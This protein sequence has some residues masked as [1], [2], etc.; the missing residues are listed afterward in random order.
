MR[1]S[2]QLGLG[3]LLVAAVALPAAESDERRE[4]D[5]HLL[6]DAGV[7]NDSAALLN[8]FRQ[9]TI[10]EATR[11]R[12]AALIR[13]LGDDDFEMREKA[14][15]ELAALGPQ[16]EPALRQAV[17]AADAEIA[18]RARRCLQGRK[19][20]SHD[21]VAAAAR[22]LAAVRPPQAVE[23]LLEYLPSACYEPVE[24]EIAGLLASLG[25]SEGRPHQ[26][27][28][29]AAQDKLAV[30][31]L[32]A[33][34]VLARAGAMHRPAAHKLLGDPE[35]RVRLFASQSLLAVQDKSAVPTLIALLGDGPAALVWQAEDQLY[36]IA[37]DKPPQASLD[38]ASAASREKCRAAWEAWWQANEERIDLAKLPADPQ[39][40]GL[41]VIG[42]FDGRGGVGRV[43][44]VGPDGKERWRIDDVPGPAD[45]RVLPNGRVLIAEH[46]GGRVT[47]RT[48]DGKV[49]WEQRVAGNPVSCQRLPNG[50]TFIAT[51]TELLEVTR[52]GK[53]VY[54]HAKP[55][56]IYR[57]QKLANGHILY[58]HSNSQIVEIESNGREVRTIPAGNTGGWGSVEPLANGRFLIS[59]YNVGK[60]KEIDANGKVY[61]E[62]NVPSAT[63]ATR[64]SNGHTLAADT[65]N[66][67]IVEFDSLGKEVGKESVIGRPFCVRRR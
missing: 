27:L 5:K 49:V 41:T 66:R 61:L 62:C 26:A 30:R 9:R 60:V 36:R 28:V 67:R 51:Y 32:A 54:S 35:P 57:A 13:Q 16:A 29:A 23:V 1:R 3:F 25:I 52:D 42:D 44:E 24:E 19:P 37:G 4:H 21:V 39:L 6:K 20:I 12:V 56:S 45:V 18:E 40:L 22:S 10:S 59:L 11:N 55:S 34:A 64:L 47:E 38:P 2:L 8:F 53:T 15:G 50:N 7:A 65:Q 48:R 63:F 46:N 33:A 14:T 58:V 43:Y 31:R 17:E